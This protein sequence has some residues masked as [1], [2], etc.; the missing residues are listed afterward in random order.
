MQDATSMACWCTASWDDKGLWGMHGHARA[1]KRQQ[2]WPPSASIQLAAARKCL[3]A[4]SHGENVHQHPLAPMLYGKPMQPPILLL[5]LP[6][7]GHRCLRRLA[8]M[9]PALKVPHWFHPRLVSNALPSTKV[10]LKTHYTNP[11]LPAGF[12]CHL[13]LPSGMSAPD[14]AALG[15]TGISEVHECGGVG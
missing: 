6:C 14:G 10:W 2:H 4:C 8:A 5:P 9:L 13:C 11:S 15:T 7:F 12:S 1:F 3:P